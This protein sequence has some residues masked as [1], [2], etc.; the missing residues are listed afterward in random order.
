MTPSCAPAGDPRQ[1]PV[2]VMIMVAH[3]A[4]RGRRRGA[5]GPEVRTLNSL[6]LWDRRRVMPII[7]YSSQGSLISL[8][9]QAEAYH[10][11]SFTGGAPIKNFR[12][13]V[14]YLR[15][16]GVQ[17]VH[18]YGPVAADF[19]TTLAA[20]RAGVAAV[21]TRPVV[22]GDL[23]NPWP[24]RAG[25]RLLDRYTLAAA[26]KVVAIC[27]HGR[28]QLLA[29]GCDPDKLSVIH[30]GVDT[31]RFSPEAA[32]DR[33]LRAWAGGDLLIGMCAQM[34]PVK[35]HDLLL[36]ALAL[37]RGQGRP[38]RAVLAGDGPRR[39]ELARLAGEL[40]VA[41]A[42]RMPG[43]VRR[44]ESLYAAC[45]LVVLPSDR[46][47]FP[48]SLLEAM[49]CGRAVAAS[50]AGGTAELIDGGGELLTQNTAEE[51]AA[52]LE[53]LADAGLRQDLG[54][55]GRAKVARLYTIEGMIRSLEELYLATAGG[56]R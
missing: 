50:D 36:R 21:I 30:N 26:A 33:E 52:A 22:I 4:G 31:G 46:E 28:E 44:T 55:A 2:R 7:A 51:L 53:K 38:W 34:T 20:R 25:L 29:D 48:M 19:L 24:V 18:S 13:L 1:G 16:A 43:F 47:G 45:D 35:R 8:A 9:R 49:A 56:V 11:I 15:A 14:G 5:G 42:V 37:G 17:V 41:E 23:K 40:G 3:A 32:P 6:H 39:D 10:D 12:R 54:L 27:Q